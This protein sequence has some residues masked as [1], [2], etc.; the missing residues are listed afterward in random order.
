MSCVITHLLCVIGRPF[1]SVLVVLLCGWGQWSTLCFAKR[2]APVYEDPFDMA[3]GG[4]SLTR[5]SQAG[6][7]FSNPA[8]IPYGP[9]FHRWVG[10]ETTLLVGKDSVDFARTL[11]K[12][13]SS[14]SDSG[15]S[16][17][18]SF[19]DQVMKTPLHAGVLNNFSYMNRLFGFST[20]NRGEFDIAAKKFGD[21]GLPAIRFRAESY[22]GV[23]VSAATFLPTQA[24]SFGVTGKYLYAGEPDLAIE[25]T[26]QEKIKSLQSS[27]G[28]KSLIGMNTGFGYDAGLLFFS[29]GMN[30]DYR[31]ALKIDDVGDTKLK[32]DANLKALK[33][34][35]SVGLGY[36]LH[37]AVDAIHLS[38][39]YRDIQKVY[40]EELFKRVRVGTKILIRRHIGFG[41][42]YYDGWPSYGLELDAWIIR[43]TAAYYTRELGAKPGIDPRPVYAIGFTMGF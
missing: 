23:G 12:G 8:L 27:S 11:Q 33:Q 29:Q 19:I 35:Y 34:S 5:A 20:F 6:M 39:D 31:L 43:L 15:P 24:I 3:S 2:S 21:T 7:I 1:R 10:N 22:Q 17:T 28:L 40:Q 32:G 18:A 36:T 42:G 26:D 9:G 13:T 14:S 30:A 4:A 41:L 37:N 25:L 38:V 16:G